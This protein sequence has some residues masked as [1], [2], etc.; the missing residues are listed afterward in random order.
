MQ[1]RERRT[2]AWCE[3]QG[4][5]QRTL[6]ASLLVRAG[7]VLSAD[8][9]IHELWGDAPPAGAANALQAHV[10][11]LR[12]RLR[13]PG[14]GGPERIST[15]A[16]GYVLHLGSATTDAQH[17]LRLSARGRAAADADPAHA[18]E[19]LRRA[20]ELW[21][22]PALEGCGR[23]PLCGRE[24]DR[25]EEVRLDTLEAFHEA[26]LRAPGGAAHR[27]RIAAEL[28]RLTA[29]HPLRER[30]YDLLMTALHGCGRRTEALG[31]YE[32]ARRHLLAEL[33]VEPGPALRGRLKTVLHR[34]EDLGGEVA[35]LRE[36]VET[37][38]RAQ[39]EL[40]RRIVRLTRAAGARAD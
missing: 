17:F 8:R 21:R 18:A 19:V 11:R 5:K 4:S 35:R 22:G 26:G 13:G 27:A 25:L 6:L 1:A 16:T 24:A 20:L 39:E 2:G 31:V 30:F 23:G 37:L 12:R 3:P 15:H 14:D 10:A 32:R 29:E 33:G 40:T 28:E 36:R 9:L 7:E 34:P 38:S